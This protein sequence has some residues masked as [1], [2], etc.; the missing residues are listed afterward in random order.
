MDENIYNVSDKQINV[1]DKTKNKV[2]KTLKFKKKKNYTKKN[3][4]K[5][6]QIHNNNTF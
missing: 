5:L 3:T 2:I 4:V 6:L 1:K